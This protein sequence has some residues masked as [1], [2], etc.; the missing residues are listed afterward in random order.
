[1]KN[2]ENKKLEL[3]NLIRIAQ[4]DLE[5]GTY[6]GSEKN[7]VKKR[8]YYTELLRYLET[9]PKIE[10]VQS[11]KKRLTDLIK[12]KESQFE[13]WFK[14]GSN[15]PVELLELPKKAKTFFNKEHGLSAKKKKLANLNFLLKNG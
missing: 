6:K 8:N 4:N 5:N 10:F 12:A 14:E 13:D 7:A 11:E 1:M 15:V 3:K 2:F 9:E